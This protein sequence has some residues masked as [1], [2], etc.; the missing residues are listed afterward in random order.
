M[1]V[2][3]LDQ[4]LFDAAVDVL[5]TMFFSAVMGDAPPPE[6]KSSWISARLSFH[7]SPSGS[8]GVGIPQDCGRK[9]AAMFLGLEEE[10]VTELQIGEVVCELTNMLCG[11]VLSRLENDTRF[12]LSHP[13]LVPASSNCP[14]GASRVCRVLELEEGTLSVW[15]EMEPAL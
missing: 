8:F 14:E 3:E 13:E 12:D 6:C 5:E 10:S 15:L 2:S 11:S 4:I 9:I 7:G 1:P